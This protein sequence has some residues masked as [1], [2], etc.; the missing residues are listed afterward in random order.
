MA[1]LIIGHTKTS[2]VNRGSGGWLTVFTAVLDYA[3]RQVGNAA[4]T[5]TPDDE[6]LT[7]VETN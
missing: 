7:A 4:V 6:F 2:P 3:E 5:V 1:R